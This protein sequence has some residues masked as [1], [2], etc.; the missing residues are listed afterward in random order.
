MGDHPIVVL[1]GGLC[2]LSAAYHLQQKKRVDYLLLESGERV[3]GLAT[4]QSYEGFS[5][6]RAIHVLYPR[7]AYAAHL[8]TERLLAGTAR[9][10]KRSSYC[11]SDGIYT[12]YPYQL[13]SFGLPP[14]VIIDNVLGLIEAQSVKSRNSVVP[15]LEAW[16]Y[17]THGRGMAERFMIPYNRRQWAWDLK[18]MNYDWTED[19]VPALDLRGVLLGALRPQ[20][21]AYGPNREF[22]YPAE[23]GIEALARS[24]LHYIPAERIWLNATVERID[25]GR[26]E[27]V[28]A[29]GR[30]VCYAK[31]ISTLPL[32]KTVGL[33]G[34]SIPKSVRQR[35]VELKSNVLHTVNLG[36][37]GAGL[38]VKMPMHWVY[39]ADAKAPF[40]RLS[41]PGTLSPSMVPQGCCS[42]Q[43]EISESS[44]CRLN[45]A[46]LIEQTLEGLVRVGILTD[47]EARPVSAGGRVRLSRVETVDPAYVIFDLKHGENTRVLRSHLSSLNISTYGRFGEW[48]YLN[49]DQVIV[50]G[51]DAAEHAAR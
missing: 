35:C 29:D 39:F 30:R 38:S 13:N 12:E 50:S 41:F 10:Q 25:S 20:G 43:A 48:A 40:H 22:L 14:E 42:I 44:Q 47:R 6:D 7:D 16:I 1:G 17:R 26:R 11:Y 33:V 27:I 19:R 15:H 36:L 3:G 37:D 45:R 9:R 24:F 49:M 8:I 5:F 2:G 32:P 31:L 18:E 4:T 46:T 21:N 51:K 34:E 28:L 23:G